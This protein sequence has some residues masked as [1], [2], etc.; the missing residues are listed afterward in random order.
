MHTT[1]LIRRSATVALRLAAVGGS[2]GGQE[3]LLLLARPPRLLAGAVAVD[4][5]VDFP[6]QYGNFPDQK[7]QRLAQDEVGGTP[8]T[9]PAAFAA[10]SPLTYAPAIAAS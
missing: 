3:T 2:I 1:T 10:R 7:L 9:S 5:L 8:T 6:R 4:P